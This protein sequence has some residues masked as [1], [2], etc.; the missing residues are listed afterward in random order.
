MV[1]GK[2]KRGGNSLEENLAQ[3]REIREG[4]G[5]VDE[6]QE[7]QEEDSQCFV[8]TA[9]YGTPLA[10]EVNTMRLFR[11]DF[12]LE[13][14]LGRLFVNTYYRIGPPLARYISG[15]FYLRRLLRTFILGPVVKAVKTTH[16]LWSS[17]HTKY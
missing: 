1:F 8:V 3:W 16:N 12:L 15:H 14:S 11:D 2:K 9:V 13:F 6:Q 5:R 17:P 10:R 7:G 4:K